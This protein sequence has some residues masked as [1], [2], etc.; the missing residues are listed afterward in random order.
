MNSYLLNRN[1]ASDDI[2]FLNETDINY[3]IKTE[4][5]PNDSGWCDYSTGAR[6]VMASDRVIFHPATGEE[7]VFLKLKYLT[8]LVVH[9]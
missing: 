3:D 9:A 7:E 6:L 1:I 2:D 4:F 8:E 5:G